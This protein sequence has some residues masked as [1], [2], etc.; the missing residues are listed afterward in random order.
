MSH[1]IRTPLNAIVGFSELIQTSE[2]NEEK[3]EYMKIINTN[4][5]LLL[6]LIDDIL[7]LAKIE[8]NS[9][10]LQPETFDLVVVLKEIYET[11]LPK[12]EAKGI[13]LTTS[14]PH[15]ICTVILD[16]NR[17][18]QIAVNFLS[19]AIKYTKQGEIKLGYTYQENGIKL[20][21]ED[22]GVGISS[23]NQ[24]KLFKRFEKLNSLTQGTGL[25]LSICKALVDNMK[26]EIGVESK[27]GK[28]SLFWAWIPCEVDVKT[29]M[30]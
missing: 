9:I 16:R 8:S 15:P 20:Y 18:I 4:N 22:T 14:L 5:T 26:G 10:E 1:E 11:N 13:H 21:V 27:P 23:E 17:M 25:G 29:E 7:D 24:L 28:G 6:R 19:N 30:S 3:E 12:C 2:N